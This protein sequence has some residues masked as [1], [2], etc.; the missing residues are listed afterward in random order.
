VHTLE[1]GGRVA[2]LLRQHRAVAGVPSGSRRYSAQVSATPLVG[3]VSE[4]EALRLALDRLE[5][6]GGGVVA[7]EGE[8]G[9]GKSRLVAEV[10]DMPI[11][12]W[13]SSRP[14]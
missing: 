7:I 1:V 14:G 10:L 5:D 13:S 3:R 9:I 6:R 2:T 8:P 12:S 11:P 4:L